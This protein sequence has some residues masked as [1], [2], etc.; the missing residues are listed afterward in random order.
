MDQPDGN[1]RVYVTEWVNAW[2]STQSGED[3]HDEAAGHFQQT[4]EGR[5]H[6]GDWRFTAG[7][8]DTTSVCLRVPNL[9][10]EWRGGYKAAVAHAQEISEAGEGPAAVVLAGSETERDLLN[11]GKRKLPG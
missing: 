3:G 9:R 5:L 10:S 6:D 2:T 1:Y 8:G 4:W 7:A 11:Y